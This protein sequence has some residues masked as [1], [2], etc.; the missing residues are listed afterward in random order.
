MTDKGNLK[1]YDISTLDGQHLGTI[2]ASA[3]QEALN[4]W[5]LL[6]ALLATESD[7]KP[8]TAP[9]A[10][11]RERNGGEKEHTCTEFDHSNCHGCGTASGPAP[12]PPAPKHEHEFEQF[13]ELHKVAWYVDQDL[14]SGAINFSGWRTLVKSPGGSWYPCDYEPGPAAE[15]AR[16]AGLVPPGGE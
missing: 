8:W 9:A 12:E 11:K 2:E 4:L 10:P 3:E 14:T 7:G 15:I 1:T 13:G 5:L 6:G 16:L